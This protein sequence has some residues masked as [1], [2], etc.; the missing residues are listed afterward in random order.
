MLFWLQVT[1]IKKGLAIKLLFVWLLGQ[2][3]PDRMRMLKGEFF[4]Y[5]GDCNDLETTRDE[6]RENFVQA[7]NASMYSAE[8]IGVPECDAKY[9]NV[10][11]GPTSARR[12]REVDSAYNQ[13]AIAKR[14]TQPY[15]YVV[16]FEIGVPFQPADGQS[17]EDR[18][19]EIDDIMYKM[20]IVLQSEVNAGLF[21]IDGFTTDGNSVGFGFTEYD[22]PIGTRSKSAKASC[23]ML[24]L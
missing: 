7:L 23:G 10:T 19:W 13:H 17:E 5:C 2:Y 1:R 11:F 20:V 18:F 14:Q 12:R 24:F 22:C 4:Y 6:I 3:R 15:A 16:E 9:V 21:D 8:C